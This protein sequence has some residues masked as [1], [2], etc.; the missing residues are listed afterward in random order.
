M[1]GY[2]EFLAWEW[3][4]WERERGSELGLEAAKLMFLH[5]RAL[6]YANF[7]CSERSLATASRAHEAAQFEF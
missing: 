2:E 1:A 7:H 4:I 6:L 3:S 5:K